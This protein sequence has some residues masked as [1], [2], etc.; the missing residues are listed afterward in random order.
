MSHARGENVLTPSRSCVKPV[1]VPQKH[2]DALQRTTREKD[3]AP[4]VG[5]AQPD[6]DV[7]ISPN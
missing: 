4:R 3:E 2:D 6:W 7:E 1:A 5:E